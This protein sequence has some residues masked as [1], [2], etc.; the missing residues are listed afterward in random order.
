MPLRWLNTVLRAVSGN[1]CD[2]ARF[3]QT[4]M[5][6]KKKWNTE[7]DFSKSTH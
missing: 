1:L 4:N 2:G 3:R 5:A 7:D 6:A